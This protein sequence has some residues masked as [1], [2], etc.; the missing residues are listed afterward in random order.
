MML[1]D[2]RVDETIEAEG[3]V[4]PFTATV[5]C[6]LFRFIEFSELQHPIF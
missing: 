1:Y 2:N 5:N 4:Q 3:T 6:M